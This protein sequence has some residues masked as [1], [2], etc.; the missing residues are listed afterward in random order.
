MVV[1]AITMPIK[2]GMVLNVTVLSVESLLPIHMVFIPVAVDATTVDVGTSLS[3]VVF[4]R[5][6]VTT[7]DYSCVANGTLAEQDH[8]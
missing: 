7:I 5:S 6:T 3:L 2:V 4:N 8:I 1:I